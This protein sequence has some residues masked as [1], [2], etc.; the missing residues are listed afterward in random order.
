MAFGQNMHRCTSKCGGRIAAVRFC[1]R[2]CLG[3]GMPDNAYDYLIIGS[4]P[5][6]GLVAGQLQREHGKRVCLVAEPYSAFGLERRFDLS[7]DL[8]TRPETLALLKR[9][10]GET[11]KLIGTIG[12]NL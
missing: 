6:A 1:G 10:A 2:K 8:V 4:T 9:L 12:K 5:L 3:D 11:Q 7:I